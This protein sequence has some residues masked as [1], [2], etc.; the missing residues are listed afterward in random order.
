MGEPSFQT[1][2]SRG[3]SRR[4]VS[5]IELMAILTIVGIAAAIVVPRLAVSS[6]TAKA[7]DN[8]HNK[9]VI[10]SAVERWYIEK[11]DWPKDNLSDI[12]A[13]R[14]YFPTGLPTNPSD[15]SGYSLNSATHRVE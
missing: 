8:A 3:R 5:L 6:D 15:N 4:G 10:N 12:G 7:M 2:A 9:A 1:V 11:G 13:D 14:N